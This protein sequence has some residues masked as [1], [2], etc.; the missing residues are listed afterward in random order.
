MLAQQRVAVLADLP[1]LPTYSK[2]GEGI[3]KQAVGW[4]QSGS[5]QAPAA[6]AKECR[7]LSESP[8]RPD[9]TAPRGEDP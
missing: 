3:G 7:I 5:R 2:E 6:L 8:E 9:P 1:T 4:G